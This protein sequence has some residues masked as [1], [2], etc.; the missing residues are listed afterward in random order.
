MKF[1]TIMPH[2]YKQWWEKVNVLVPA[3]MEKYEITKTKAIIETKYSS[4]LVPL[5]HMEQFVNELTN[6][7]VFVR[8]NFYNLCYN[9]KCNMKKFVGFVPIQKQTVKEN[10][11]E[12]LR[13]L[14]SNNIV[15]TCEKYGLKQVVK[16]LKKQK[17]NSNWNNFL[18]CLDIVLN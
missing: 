9:Q 1:M 7:N 17:D 2:D 13:F 15:K 10:N 18:P 11:E 4:L 14:F 5:H 6:N 16:L 3:L 12:V 8:I